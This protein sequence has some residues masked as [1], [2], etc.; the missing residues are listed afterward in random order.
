M[1]SGTLRE[2]STGSSASRIGASASRRSS[3]KSGDGRSR[4]ARSKS[5]RERT[6]ATILGRVLYIERRD[7]WAKIDNRLLA[8]P[9]AAPEH[10]FN[11][12][13]KNIE[14]DIDGVAGFGALEVGVLFSVRRNPDNETF[15]EH[16]GNGQTDAV[17]GD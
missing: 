9:P 14:L 6:T 12:L 16:F 3:T 15:R 10:P 7:T 2:R 1:I 11:V 17:D 4:L 5:R 8:F 13:G